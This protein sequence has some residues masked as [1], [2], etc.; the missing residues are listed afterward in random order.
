MTGRHLPAR[1]REAEATAAFVG[2]LDPDAAT[3][4]LDDAARDREPEPG[5]FDVLVARL[6]SAEE[7]LEHARQV[8]RGNAGAVIFDRA[9][10]FLAF[11]GG[12]EPH[13]AARVRELDRIR[14]QVHEQALQ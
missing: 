13:L 6:T 10:P 4:Q 3:V 8:L 7:T 5:A 1:D 2:R 14:Q 12:D 9:E 11:R